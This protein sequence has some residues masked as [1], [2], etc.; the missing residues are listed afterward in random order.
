[1]HVF[2][3]RSS[4]N[5]GLVELH[6]LSSTTGKPHPLAK[7]AALEL[8]LDDAIPQSDGF[9]MF[10]VQITGDHIGLYTDH[11]G[12]MPEMQT[13]IWVCDWKQ[14][15]VLLVCPID[16]TNFPLLVAQIL[17][18]DVHGN[19]SDGAAQPLDFAFLDGRHILI[20]TGGVSPVR[21]IVAFDCLEFPSGRYPM[22][23]AIAEYSSLVLDLPKLARG[24]ES[25]I[26][27]SISSCPRLSSVVHAAASATNTEGTPWFRWADDSPVVV[28]SINADDT[29]GDD[30][31]YKI[32]IPGY[33]LT[34]RLAATCEPRSAASCGKPTRA[35]PWAEWACDALL[36]NSAD[37]YPS[38]AVCGSK[39]VTAGRVQRPSEDGELVQYTVAMVYHFDSRASIAQD[40]NVDNEEEL[41]EDERSSE[42]PLVYRVMDQHPPPI[43]DPK[44]WAETVGGGAWYRQICS[45]RHG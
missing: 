33:T 29:D 9:N 4:V 40:R 2:L 23:T 43:P 17:S 28:I 42:L 26:A 32:L 27:T 38:P 1:M 31:A 37:T 10:R 13:E 5:G 44:M 34:A 35:V 12:Y 36:K 18:Q 25:E 24:S 15:K 39:Y 11:C 20:I 7:E 14:C 16:I 6:L 30:R 45:E 41:D 19:S 8:A 22:A 21:A 3:H